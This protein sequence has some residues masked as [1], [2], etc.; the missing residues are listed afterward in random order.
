MVK[1]IENKIKLIKER[2]NDGSLIFKSPSDDTLFSV[3]ELRTIL[4]KLMGIKLPK[5]ST[6]VQRK[7]WVTYEVLKLLG[8]K[9]PSGLRT[10]EA[11]EN[12]PKFKHQLMDIFVQKHSNLQIWNYVPY[13]IER[14][15]CRYVIFKVD[16]EKIL[17]LI[18]KTGKELEDWDIT[19]TKTIKWQATVTNQRRE[20]A[21]NRILLSENDPIFL[22]FNS[23]KKDLEPIENRIETIKKLRHDERSLLKSGPNVEI[24]VTIEELGVLLKPLLNVKIE[25]TSEKIIGQNFQVLV[26]KE[27]GYSLEDGVSMNSGQIPDMIHQLIETKLQIS[28]TIDLG[29]HLPISNEPLTSVW[30]KNQLTPRDVRYIIA[31]ADKTKDGL[32]Q[33]KGIIITSGVDFEKFFSLCEGTNF[34]V[35]MTIPS[36]DNI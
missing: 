27:L 2:D 3:L 10:K 23:N 13:T 21:S 18:I 31:L 25:Y 16:D 19:G 4:K 5:E 32:V 14:Y 8:Y 34:K 30:N 35:Q 28:P 36:F 6:I 1:M 26:A 33:I 9:K 20:S 12:K 22:K 24:L 11:R 29:Y 7:H 17:G 15:K